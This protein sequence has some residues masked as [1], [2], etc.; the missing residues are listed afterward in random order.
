[1]ANE[2]EGPRCPACG[3]TGPYEL[4]MTEHGDFQV[5]EI[6]VRYG[7]WEVRVRPGRMRAIA[8]R[9]LRCIQANGASAPCGTAIPM[10]EYARVVFVA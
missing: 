5:L 6:E 7:V 9:A 8:T 1:M 3:H 2:Y 10:P 4:V